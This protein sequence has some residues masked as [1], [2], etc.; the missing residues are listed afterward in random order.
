MAKVEETLQAQ[1]P[2]VRHLE[3]SYTPTEPEAEEDPEELRAEELTGATEPEE[4]QVRQALL[5]AQTEPDQ[6]EEE[7][8]ADMTIICLTALLRE[9]ATAQL[10]QS[11]KGELMTYW[12]DFAFVKEQKIVN[13]AVY[14]PDG[15]Y[16]AANL[17]A[18][19]FYG[20]DAIAVDVTQYPVKIGDTYENGTF[21]RDRIQI[22]PLP[23]DEEELAILKKTVSSITESANSASEAVDSIIISMAEV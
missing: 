9:E 11:G 13:I 21:L 8:S 7:L 22:D 10:S 18:K 15:A 4:D 1:D 3:A 2:E 20:S 19:Q 5:R 17:Q 6:A 14:A 23:T 12:K 16:T